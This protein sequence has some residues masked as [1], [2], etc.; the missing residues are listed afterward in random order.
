M[1]AITNVTI[2]IDVFRA[3][4]T[5]SYILERCPATYILATK[6]EVIA[7]LSSQWKNSL[8]I[9]KQEKGID[10]CS[11]EIPNSPTRTQEVE[12]AG[13]TILHRTEAGAK[14]LLQ[15][16]N[17]DIVLAAGFCNA[18]ATVR[19]L[20]TLSHIKITLSPMGHEGTSSSL[21]DLLCE[22]YIDSLL[23]NKKI[24]LSSYLPELK[25]GTGRYFFF[26]DQWQYPREDFDKCLE[27]ERF[28]FAIQASIQG[29]YA[30]MSALSLSKTQVIEANDLR[31]SLTC[32]SM[33]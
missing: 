6:C 3:F 21:E 4:T 14:G 18:D 32:V 29:D 5:A 31:N 7:R 17:A 24:N 19:Y 2:V 13:R 27:L 25:S 26:E 11:Y 30:L 15:A 28:N 12:I 9:G 22:E 10:L 33:E 23:N 16:K 1:S 8:I 20:K